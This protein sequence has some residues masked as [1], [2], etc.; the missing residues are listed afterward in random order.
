LFS[1]DRGGL[2]LNGIKKGSDLVLGRW[3]A[4]IIDEGGRALTLPL[5][6]EF[7]YSR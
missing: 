7:L 3:V 5:N 1:F 2:Y 4:S 6:F